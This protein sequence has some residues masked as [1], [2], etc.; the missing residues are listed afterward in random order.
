MA[1]TMKDLARETG[2]GLA[3]ISSYFNGGNVRPKNREKIE[4][5][6]E[7]LHLELNETARGLK[8][9]RSMMVG[10]VIPELTSAFCAQ[11]LSVIEDRLR[12]HGYGMLVCDCR[13][14][15]ER[16]KE[17]V[18]FLMRRRVDGIFS[19]PVDIK[20]THLKQFV[21]SGKPAVIIDREID[22]PG[23]DSVCVD[24]RLAIETGMRRLYEN[25]HRRIGLIV[26]EQTNNASKQ[27]RKGYLQACAQLGIPGDES[28]IYIGSET[29]ECGAEGMRTL[30]TRCPDM[31]AVIAGSH[32]ITVG[33]LIELN[34]Q[35][36]PV[37]ER[38]SVIGFD[39]PQ[40][41]Q[42]VHPRMAILNQPVRDIG[43]K[44]AEIMLAR[45][46][47]ARKKEPEGQETQPLPY[48][49]LWLK[50]S[51]INGKSVKNINEQD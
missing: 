38:I 23:F 37:P 2:L 43:E 9:N 39:D 42:A 48:Q 14:D 21:S 15:R 46:Q 22:D 34:A 31:T 49:H 36:I 24:N 32:V 1:A 12:S 40:F 6:I 16:E 28:L 13:S 11:V 10:A 20:G 8:T 35:S 29:V 33:M 26:G 41:A 30:L 45:L 4:K 47:A 50:A 44:A 18:E 7:K 3:T 51:F 19:I 17:A 25:G 27:R 5:A